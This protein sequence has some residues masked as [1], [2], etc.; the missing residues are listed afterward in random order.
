MEGRGVH[1]P[2]ERHGREIPAECLGIPDIRGAVFPICRREAHD[3]W[4][5]AK[6]IEK[7]VGS[8]V[9]IAFDSPRRDPTDRPWCDDGIKW[10]V[11]EPVSL[12][13]LVEVDVLVTW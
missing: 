1:L 13:R 11:F 12:R 3:R 5:V 9:N 6:G 2:R 8:K 4:F 7:A 10:V